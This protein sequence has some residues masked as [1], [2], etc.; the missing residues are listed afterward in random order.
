MQATFKLSV[1][2]WLLAVTASM[3]AFAA[4]PPAGLEPLPEVLP[5]PGVA[6]DGTSVLEPEVTI[7]K[8]GQDT[9][10]E[11]RINGEL[12]MMKITPANGGTPYYLHKE[13]QNGG[14]IN[15]GPSQPLSVP[16]WVIFKF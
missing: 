10:E 2:A 3:G 9:V 1:V 6:E 7:V 4:E 11:Y 12:Y 16:K 15:D 8:K 5:P 14:W 13:D